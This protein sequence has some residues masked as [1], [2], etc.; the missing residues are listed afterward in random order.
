MR[1]RLSTKILEKE[2]KEKQEYTFDE[3]IKE[4][5]RRVRNLLNSQDYVVIALNAEGISVGKTYLSNKIVAMMIQEGIASIKPSTDSAM[6]RW[7]TDFKYNQQC[8]KHKNKGVV[9]LEA[10]ATNMTC[11]PEDLMQIREFYDQSL[12]IEAS[13]LNLPL[14][15]IDLWVA[16]YRP[17]QPFYLKPGKKIFGDIIIRNEQARV[18]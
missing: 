17:D 14:Q 4:I 11:L 12:E 8:S 10:R 7:L 3:G 15:K 2:T 6:E 9:V 18:D 5:I 1:E 13:K 16:I